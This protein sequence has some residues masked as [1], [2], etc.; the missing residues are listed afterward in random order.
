MGHLCFSIFQISSIFFCYYYSFL[1]LF[2]LSRSCIN[3]NTIG[4]FF[5][6]YSLSHSLFFKNGSDNTFASSLN[7]LPQGNNELSLSFSVNSRLSVC[8]ICLSEF[9]L[10][11]TALKMTLGYL[12]IALLGIAGL[13]WLQET[14]EGERDFV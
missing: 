2:N 5:L 1:M 6:S 9:L 11:P 10:R 14:R 13:P 4:L 7:S 12:V 8:Y 3:T